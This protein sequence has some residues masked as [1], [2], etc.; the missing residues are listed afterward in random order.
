MKT[1]ASSESSAST[2]TS[3]ATAPQKKA[4]VASPHSFPAMPAAQ[5]YAEQYLM[6]TAA[7]RDHWFPVAFADN[8]DATTMIPFDLFNVPWWGCDKSNAVDTLNPVDTIA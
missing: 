8:L 5:P 1:D 4:A 7:E 3:T 2:S 6:A